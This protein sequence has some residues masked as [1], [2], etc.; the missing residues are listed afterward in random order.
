MAGNFNYINRENN[1]WYD[2]KIKNNFFKIS[3]RKNIHPINYYYM[4]N[5]QTILTPSVYGNF[6]YEIENK[7]VLKV[8]F[9]AQ[10]PNYLLYSFNLA[11]YSYDKNSELIIIKMG[12]K[13][14]IRQYDGTFSFTI[15]VE[16]KDCK[17]MIYLNNESNEVII[18]NL[19]VVFKETF[20]SFNY[21][22]YQLDIL[23]D[24]T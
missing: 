13:D 22:G 3:R 19:T 10:I 4:S 15:N 14:G 5:Q 12:R 21:P 17:E 18:N 1:S 24:I 2:E 20:L 8:I 16:D 23:D 9:N 6:Y 7:Y 11:L